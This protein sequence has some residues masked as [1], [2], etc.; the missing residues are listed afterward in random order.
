MFTIMALLVM[1]GL[2]LYVC[3]SIFTLFIQ[4]FVVLFSI[5]FIAFLIKAFVVVVLIAGTCAL[6]S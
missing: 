2:A 3:A 1:F 5:A 4:M 6:V